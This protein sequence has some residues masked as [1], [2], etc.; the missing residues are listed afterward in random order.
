MLTN[1]C[2]GENACF[3]NTVITSTTSDP[4]D[5]MNTAAQDY[6][7]REKGI[8]QVFKFLH[9]YEGQ[10]PACTTEISH[11]SVALFKSL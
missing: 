6:I 10:N 3:T 11:E 4:V 2:G 1:L 5:I 8:E 7:R 9:K